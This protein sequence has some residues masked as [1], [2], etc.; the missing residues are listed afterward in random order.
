MAKP[1]I[2]DL[3]AKQ[4]IEDTT[5]AQ[6]NTATSNSSV[7]ATSVEFWKGPITL[8]RVLQVR[9]Y[10][11]GLP[12]PELSAIG[13]PTS[14]AAEGTIE[15]KPTGTEIWE[16]KAIRGFGV[17]GACETTMSYTD[18]TTDL[19]FRVADTIAQA[20]T[21]Y[22]LNEKVSTPMYLTSSMW[23]K[24]E[25]TGTSNGLM[26]LSAYTTVGL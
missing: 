22:D 7:D 13:G 25:E 21:N 12:I 14:V 17:G 24:I 23:L 16:I 10:P 1:T 8:Q 2:Y 6:L 9:T 26:I 15:L 4:G 3:L 5:T 18:G 20:G 11:W 19:N